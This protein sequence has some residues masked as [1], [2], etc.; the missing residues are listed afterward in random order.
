MLAIAGKL[1]L[2]PPASR[3][4]VER[5]EGNVLRLTLPGGGGGP[6]GRPGMGMMS[7]GGQSINSDRFTRS[8]Y[9]PIVRDQVPD[10]LGVFDFAEPSLVTG[11]REDTTVPSQALY[12]MN[13]ASVQKIAEA[14]AARL[15]ATKVTG[16][17]LGKKAFELAY[18]RPPTANELKATGEFFARFKAAEA[19]KYPDK[20]KLGFAGL[21][22][23]CQALIGSAEFRYLN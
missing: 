14:M 22:A 2:T 5:T 6:F 9:E 3:S 21:T 4:L 20:D 11:D 17:E 1:D 12:L 18:S 19:Q 10:S 8:V 16:T 23:F 13:S 7:G 15:V